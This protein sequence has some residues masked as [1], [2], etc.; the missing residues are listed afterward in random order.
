M[1]RT[2][3]SFLATVPNSCVR[4]Q[5]RHLARPRTAPSR[6]VR[7]CRIRCGVSSSQTSQKILPAWIPAV[8]TDVRGSTSEEL[9][10][11]SGGSFN[12]SADPKST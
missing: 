12:S 2:D 4:R 5:F 11:G 6:P 9:S 7:I 1:V 3:T 10:A 8:L